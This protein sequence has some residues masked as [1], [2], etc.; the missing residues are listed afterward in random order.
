MTDHSAAICLMSRTRHDQ[1]HADW[2]ISNVSE[3]AG[4]TV[5]PG[6]IIYCRTLKTSCS[7]ADL[8]LLN[9]LNRGCM[10]MIIF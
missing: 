5:V 9:N 1:V 4:V 8:S 6:P 10:S 7:P 2:S 3:G